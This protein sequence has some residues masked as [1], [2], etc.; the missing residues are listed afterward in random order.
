MEWIA[1]AVVPAVSPGLGHWLSASVFP[2]ALRIF[3]ILLAFGLTVFVHE[4]GHFITARLSGM[5]V[6]EFSLGF[7]RPRLFGFRRKDTDYSIRL[8]PFLSYVRIAGMEMGEEEHPNG[9]STK[10]R[11]AQAIVLASGCVMNFLL[12]VAIFIAMNMVL[13]KGIP[14]STIEQV[15][16]K[17]PAAVAGLQ[18]GDRLVGVNGLHTTSVEKLREVISGSPGRPIT[19]EVERGTEH[20]TLTVTPRPDKGYEMK[21][22]RIVP[23]RIGLIGVLFAS[24]L[25]HMGFF[26]S[27]GS[28]FVQTY[29]LLQFQLASIGAMITKT[30]PGAEV[31][32]PVGV[33]HQLYSQAQQSW[34][35]FISMAALLTVGVGFL[36][37]MPLPALDGSRLVVV[38]Y[39]A[40]LGHSVDKRKENLVHLVGLA[41]LLSLILFLTYKDI[42]RWVAPGKG[43]G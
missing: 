40:I 41:V 7:G 19:L 37:L 9:F 15:V 42:L 36:N 6:Y 5:H 39:E 26:E 29:S 8:W 18:K 28:G 30:V 16:A 27:I 43:G 25:V 14:N 10:P 33:V 23:R 32:G 4:A 35:N 11:W 22:L 17:T 13:G 24:R 38:I 31:M 20:L 12:A 3:A 21:G 2:V 1:A 34:I